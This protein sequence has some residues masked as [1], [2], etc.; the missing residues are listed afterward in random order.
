MQSIIQSTHKKLSGK[1]TG[2]ACMIQTAHCACSRSLTVLY[3]GSESSMRSEIH[4]PLLLVYVL[5]QRKSMILQDLRANSSHYTEHS[6]FYIANSSY[7][8]AHSL[9]HIVHSSYH[10]AHSLYYIAHHKSPNG[11]THVCPEKSAVKKR[12]TRF[13]CGNLDTSLVR[14]MIQKC[15]KNETCQDI[16]W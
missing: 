9:Y 10:I 1:R 15:S 4:F 16:L 6:P 11:C 14:F 12:H 13:F 8:I 5:C 7:H 2:F 3:R